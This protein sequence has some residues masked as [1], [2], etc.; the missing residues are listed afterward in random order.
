M[1][2]IQLATEEGIRMTPERWSQVLFNDL[3]HR[4]QMQSI[5]DRVQNLSKSSKKLIDEFEQKL[6]K[7][8][9]E[10]WAMFA[11]WKNDLNRILN[12]N[13]LDKKKLKTDIFGTKFH[14]CYLFLG[15]KNLY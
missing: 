11:P 3:S 8:S 4:P 12:S 14:V 5:V 9:N 10:L 1:F 6:K 7:I 13:I 15:K 2:I